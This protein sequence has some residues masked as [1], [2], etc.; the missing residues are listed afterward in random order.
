MQSHRQ[1][2][3]LWTAL[4]QP[5]AGLHVQ[6]SVTSLVSDFRYA[7]R[8]FLRSPMLAVVALFSL[9]L[10]I[11]ANT[12]IFSLLN[13]VLLRALPVQRPSELV[14]LK[15]NG[16]NNGRVWDDGTHTSFSYPLYKDVASRKDLFNGVLAR[17][18]PA[19]SITHNGV[20]ERALAELVF[21]TRA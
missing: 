8:S 9:T 16:P 3:N 12:A 20:T 1:H 4:P 19:A 14:V 5:K 17:F 2:S 7:I 18:T 21:L 15:S 11:G 13:Q 6:M 10:G